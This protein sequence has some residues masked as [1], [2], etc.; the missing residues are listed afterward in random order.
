[1]ARSLNKVMLLGNLGSDPETRFSTGGTAITNFNIATTRRWRD[2]RSEE[3]REETDWHRVVCF[4]RNAEIASEYLSKGR[5][6]YVEGD[7]RTSSWERDGQRRERTEIHVQQLILLGGGGGQSRGGGNDYGRS[8]PRGG[9]RS[10]QGSRETPQRDTRD[11]RDSID[12]EIPPDLDD[13]IP[14]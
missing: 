14:F 2:Q 11:R 3:W 9:S 4:G 5:Q 7:L 13:D 8:P 6:V 1:M 10:S 12:D